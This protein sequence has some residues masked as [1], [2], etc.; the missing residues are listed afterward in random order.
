MNKR[1]RAQRA[2]QTSLEESA[3]DEPS[4]IF[5]QEPTEMFQQETEQE[6]EDWI[7][8]QDEL[9][10]AEVYRRSEQDYDNHIA[11]QMAAEGLTPVEVLNQGI[12]FDR[13]TK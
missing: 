4:D 11:E 12:K 6:R 8:Y 1:Q 3:S 10:E 9:R 5:H 13:K 2:Y 7:H